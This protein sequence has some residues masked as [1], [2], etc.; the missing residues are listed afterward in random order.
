RRLAG[1]RGQAR[2]KVLLERGQ[3]ACHAGRFDEALADLKAV[4][5]HGGESGVWVDAAREWQMR[6]YVA[7]GDRRERASDMAADFQL[8]Y[9]AAGTPARQAQMLVRLAK[10]RRLEAA[11]AGGDEPKKL[12]ALRQAVEAAHR[13]AESFQGQ[14]I[15]DV[16]VGAAAV[17]QAPEVPEM[18]DGLAWA[19]VTFLPPLLKEHGQACYAPWDAQAQ[20]ALAKA[21]A[22]DDLTALL[23]VRD[24]WPN[25]RHVPGSLIS[26]AECIV[27]RQTAAP[28]PDEGEMDRAYGLLA[29]AEDRAEPRALVTSLAGRAVIAA[30]RTGAGPLGWIL[31]QQI[32]QACTAA[33]ISLGEPVAFNRN[34]MPLKA[35]LE[36]LDGRAPVAAPPAP[37]PEASL[38]GPVEPLFT[39]EGDYHFIRDQAWQA[40]RQ[41][42]HLLAIRDDRLIWLDTAAP[43][44]DKALRWET[45]VPIGSGELRD[46]MYGAPGFSL[47]GA[48]AP[49]GQSVLVASRTWAMALD[50]AD[51]KPRWKEPVNI[52]ALCGGQIHSMS[53]AN[54]R[55]LV[56]NRGGRVFCL[57]GS[58][59]KVA[60]RVDLSKELLGFDAPPQMA[61]DLAVLQGCAAKKAAC[62]DL[63]TGKL[64]AVWSS[65]QYVSARALPCGLGAVLADG[66]CSLYTMA[67]S[68]PVSRA[69]WTRRYDASLKPAIVGADDT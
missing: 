37:G 65:G 30:R 42:T 13:L 6:T 25:S 24:R 40:V 9:D 48:L 27:R 38:A 18:T 67:G 26:A 56:Q 23:A 60:W 53:V 12:E 51:G 43:N 54:G 66:V 16:P 5:E 4:L 39:L 19:M 35:L 31:A 50:V 44:A 14:T 52:A 61:G 64:R 45:K 15:A 17:A 46:Y 28:A 22:A 34:D 8:A 55:L 2:C 47:V 59:G 32:R 7:R 11:Q 58:D 49:D 41:G 36:D 21:L 1:A 68:S 57:D 33:S 62:L 10:A 29:D 69:I 3:L 63:R 20:Q